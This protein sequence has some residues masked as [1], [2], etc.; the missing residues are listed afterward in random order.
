M[1]V[2]KTLCIASLV[3]SSGFSMNLN[4]VVNLT[5]SNN[6]DIESK[7]FNDKAYQKF[8]DEKN[9]AFLP[10]L[11]VTGNLKSQK[12][13]EILDNNTRSKG[14]ADG[15]NV[16][17]EFEQL[18]F[19]G[20]ELNQRHSAR[21][22]Y[23]SNKFKNLDDVESVLLNSIDSYLNV[24]KFQYTIDQTNQYLNILNKNYKIANDTYKI[25]KEVLD[26]VQTNA[27]ILSTKNKLLN[28][29]NNEK[30]AKSYFLKNVGVEIS[31][32]L[33]MPEFKAYSLPDLPTLKNLALKNNYK[34]LSQIEKIKEQR[35]IIASE[36]GRFLPTLKLKLQALYDND[37]IKDDARHDEYS[38]RIEFKYNIFNGF[39]NDA[40]TQ[41]ERLFLQEAQAKLDVVTREVLNDLSTSY[42]TYNVS[43][44]QLD[45]LESVIKENEKIVKIYNDQFRSGV[46][47]FI[48][49]LNV[50]A[51]LYNSKVDLINTKKTLHESY[52]KILK[53][54][55]ALQGTF[56]NNNKLTLNNE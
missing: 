21:Y 39:I 48:D 2:I 6:K 28:E 51:D 13:R 41:R 43:L 31:E 15:S 1:K 10:K 37:L 25:N 14:H 49:L 18:L 26:K 54:L 29:K 42:D 32:D 34:I 22:K 19:D 8:I 30:I 3:I 46:R 11:D 23:L 17:L 27:K 4:D 5:L 38:A 20:Y 45:G 52:Y 53:S 33:S 35:E 40:R 47:S 7:K 36:K 24:V 16:V 12:T 9:G 50:Q 55:S 56:L 44:E